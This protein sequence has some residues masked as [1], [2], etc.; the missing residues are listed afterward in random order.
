MNLDSL[1]AAAKGRW[2]EILSAVADIDA[3]HLDG[4]HHPCP[5]CGGVDRFRLIDEAAGAVLCNQCFNSENGDGIAAVQHF[6]GCDFKAACDRV[7]SHLKLDK[8]DCRPQSKVVATFEYRDEGGKLL[9]YVDRVEPGKK[10]KKDFV[11]RGPTSKGIKGVRRV[12]YRLPELMQADPDQPVF[13]PE[14]EKHVDALQLLGLVAT[15]NPFGAGSWKPEY[16]QSLA[17]R[18]VVILPDNDE[19]GRDHGTQVAASL[20]G[21]A[22]SVRRVYLRGLPAKGDVIDWLQ[23]GGT[24]DE[25]LTLAVKAVDEG[26]SDDRPRTMTERLKDYHGLHPPVIHDLL[27]EGE[28]MNVIAPP[29]TGKSWLVYSLALSIATGKF[30]LDTYVPEPGKVLLIDNELHDATIDTRIP[31]VAEALGI[32]LPDYGDKLEIRSLRGQLKDMATL[33]AEFAQYQPGQYKAIIIDSL[34]RTLPQGTE[35]NSNEDFTAIY[36]LIDAHAMRLK[37]AF[38]LIHHSSKGNQSEKAVTDVGSGA[39]AISRAADSHV[40]LREHEQDGVVVLDAALRSFRPIMPICLRWSF[41]LWRRE[42]GLD[43]AELKRPTSRRGRKAATARE[44][45]ERP[46]KEPWTAKRFADEF[47]TE[48]PRPKAAIVDDAVTAGVSR[49]M[50][51]YLIEGALAKELAFEHFGKR[52][53]SVKP[54]ETEVETAKAGSKPVSSGK[55]EAVWAAL[56]ETPDASNRQIAEK[57]GVTPQYVG[58][59][60]ADPAYAAAV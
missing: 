51:G 29:K 4:R 36:N 43:P 16:S 32:A 5:R 28:T 31:V 41:P 19:A 60:R 46:E 59:L 35:E 9:F 2:P 30:W 37:C 26:K 44:G 38:V 48:E 54:N 52:L 24:K 40:V 55:R 12:L 14:G 7:A 13:I 20:A 45:R 50:A 33:G 11:A 22:A 49:K 8:H 1:K 56:A 15:C 58:R 21:I 47:I 25:L 57:C 23:A 42:S 3:K 39:G 6:A 17:G 34:Y 53:A 27:R 10:A 18:H